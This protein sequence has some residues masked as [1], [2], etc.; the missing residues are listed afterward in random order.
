M[1]VLKPPSRDSITPSLIPVTALN[2]YLERVKS[3]SEGLRALAAGYDYIP[4]Q[5][6]GI[7]GQQE[8]LVSNGVVK[9]IDFK[10]NGN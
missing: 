9:I 3:T 8:A 1:A 2:L 6:G 4:L 7:L 5:F 10:V